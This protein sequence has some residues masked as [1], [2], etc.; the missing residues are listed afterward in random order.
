MGGISTF[1]QEMHILLQSVANVKYLATF[2]KGRHIFREAL[3]GSVSIFYS[4]GL[5]S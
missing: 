3:V 5:R 1:A 4:I 2:I